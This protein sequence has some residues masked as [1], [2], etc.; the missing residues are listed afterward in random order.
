MATETVGDGEG[1]RPVA[2]TAEFPSEDLLHGDRIGARSHQKDA[3]VAVSAVKPKGMRKVW[4]DYIRKITL[5]TKMDIEINGLHGYSVGVKGIFGF[6]DALLN[7]LNPVYISHFGFWEVIE[8]QRVLLFFG[9]RRL[10]CRLRP[11]VFVT[12]QRQSQTGRSSE[13]HP[14]QKPF[15][16]MQHHLNKRLLAGDDDLSCHL[17]VDE[18]EIGILPRCLKGVIPTISGFHQGKDLQ[19]ICGP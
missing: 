2:A 8:G 13:Q 12:V 19:F 17:I 1:D 18:A 4:K 11:K 7:S 6:N 5:D 3:G 15:P 9:W 14:Y 16:C 10:L